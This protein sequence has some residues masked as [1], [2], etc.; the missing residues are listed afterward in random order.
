V[1]RDKDGTESRLACDE[2]IVGTGA[3]PVRPPIAGLDQLGVEDGAHLLHSMGDTFA[4]TDSLNRCQPKTVR[5]HN[6]GRSALAVAEVGIDDSAH[7]PST[8]TDERVRAAAVV[9]VVAMKP[10]LDLPRYDGV[11]YETWEMPD[12]D[13]WDVD[14]IRRLRDH[15]DAQLHSL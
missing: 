2:L 5:T 9:V 6:A 1:L 3:V 4:L 15:I 10:G 8:L 14:S 11:R 12:P 7:R 13:A